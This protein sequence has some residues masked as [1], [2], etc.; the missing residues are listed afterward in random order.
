MLHINGGQ[1]P[2]EMAVFLDSNGV[3]PALEQMTGLPWR[4]LKSWVYTPF[5][6]SMVD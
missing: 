4:L 5:S 1:A 6:C 2:K 3:A